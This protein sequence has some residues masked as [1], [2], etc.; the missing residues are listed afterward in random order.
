MNKIIL[1]AHGG[2]ENHGCEAIIRSTA[3]LL[4]N[5]NKAS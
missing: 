1:Y 2:S 3:S 4:K 5:D